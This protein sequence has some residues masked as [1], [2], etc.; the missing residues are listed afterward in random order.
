MG[1]SGW[2]SAAEANRSPAKKPA[3]PNR[4]AEKTTAPPQNDDGYQ[5]Q[6]DN[7]NGTFR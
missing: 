7:S 1:Y 5:R 6:Y 2:A 3:H 4:L